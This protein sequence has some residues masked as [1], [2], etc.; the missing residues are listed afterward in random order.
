MGAEHYMIELKKELDNAGIKGYPSDYWSSWECLA[1]HE[2]GY[3]SGIFE[4]S[5]E[6]SSRDVIE[7]ILNLKDLERFP[8]F[9]VF[10]SVVAEDEA[11]RAGMLVN[12]L[13]NKEPWWHSI[14]PKK[15]GYE[16]IE[17]AAKLHG[18]EV[19]SKILPV[20]DW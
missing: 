11:V 9:W 12:I 13:P 15:A 19:A 2:Y 4:F 8:E 17:W 5:N 16:F 18:P 10:K 3:S 14:L 20:Q 7:D 1:G 6:L